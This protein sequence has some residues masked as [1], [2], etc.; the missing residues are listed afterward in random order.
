MAKP[1]KAK[2]AP[3]VTMGTEDFPKCSKCQVFPRTAKHSWCLECQSEH[4]VN[5]R[6]TLKQQ[7]EGSGFGKGIDAMRETLALEFERLGPVVVI[8]SEVAALIRNAPRPQLNGS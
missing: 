6:N 7:A 2:A 8:C 3:P 4:Q 5:Y 1:Q